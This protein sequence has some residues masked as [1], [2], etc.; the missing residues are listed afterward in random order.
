MCA[1][2]EQLM[3]PAKQ[4]IF[5]FGSRSSLLSEEEIR[6]KYNTKADRIESGLL[7]R[8]TTIQGLATLIPGN[9]MKKFGKYCNV[10]VRVIEIEWVSDYLRD[11]FVYLA[12]LKNVDLYDNEL[13]KVLLEQQDYS[14]QLLTFGFVPFCIYMGMC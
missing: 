6:R 12:R 7:N 5:V 11:F 9:D 13:I 2:V 8:L 4:K 1:S 3:W 10:Q 14:K